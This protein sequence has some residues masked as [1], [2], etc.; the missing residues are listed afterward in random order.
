MGQTVKTDI[1]DELFRKYYNEALLYTLSLCHSRETAEDVVSTAFFKALESADDSIKSFKPWLLSVCRNEYYSMC[2]KR[3]HM[4]DGEIP[5]AL[6]SSDEAFLDT[7][8]R[9]IGHLP[10]PQREVIT[11]FYFSGLTV[12]EAAEATGKSESNVKVLLYRAREN[13]KKFLG[14]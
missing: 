11:L 10:E 14:G 9:Q 4:S 13:L 12:R 8:I 7:I 3:K 5:E 1:I 2:R 6:S